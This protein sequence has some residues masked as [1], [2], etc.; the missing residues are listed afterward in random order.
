LQKQIKVRTSVQFFRNLQICGLYLISLYFLASL[1][2]CGGGASS[3]ASV[4]GG[5]NTS[6]NTSPTT[7]LQT[8]PIPT[9]PAWKLVWSDEFDGTGLPNPNKWGYDT[10]RN[11]VGWYNNELQYYARDRLENARVENGKL[12][13]T[14][15]KERLISTADFGNQAYTSARLVTRGIASW[16]YGFFEVRAKLPCGAGTW[17]A[18]WTLGTKGAWPADGEIDIMEQFG[19]NKTE[20]LGTI[21]TQANNFF[22]GTLGLGLGGKIAAPDSCT[23]FH[24]YQ[25]TWSADEIVIGIDDMPYFAYKNPKNGSYL[26]WPFDNPQYLILNLAIGGDLGGAVPAA[27]TSQQLEVDYVRIYQR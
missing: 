23:N 26:Q 7:P 21:H 27:F 13:I 2:A 1:S 20:V 6:A 8:T 18:I 5:V 15:R 12:I 17:P 10:S 3:A 4:A 22:N 16:T 19:N 24:N 25:L 11:Q 14:A 9:T